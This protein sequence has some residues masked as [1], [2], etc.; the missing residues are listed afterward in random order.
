MAVRHS[1]H[2]LIEKSG[3]L[4]FSQLFASAD[5]SVHVTVTPLEEHIRL[6]VP[7]KDLHYLVDVLVGSQNKV[8]S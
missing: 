1:R 5:K 3:S 8:G 7:E 2:Y 6:C 4:L